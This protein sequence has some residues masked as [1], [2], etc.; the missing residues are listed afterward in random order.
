V[1]ESEAIQT[2]TSIGE[3]AATYAAMYFTVTFAYVT[4]AYLV[5]KSLSRFQC[6]AVS[7]LYVLSATAFGAAGLGYVDAWLQ[8]KTREATILDNVWLF[9]KFVWVEGIIMM[10]LAI[11]LLSLYFM[12]DVRR[13][14]RA[15]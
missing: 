4:V 5:G 6:G 2:L 9:Q 12:Y 3:V 1:S 10:L 8:L 7:A 13:G 15:A 14:K 11:C